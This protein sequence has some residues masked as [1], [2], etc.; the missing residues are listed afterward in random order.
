MKLTG[1]KA[2]K[3]TILTAQ[4]DMESKGKTETG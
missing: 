2:R 3:L 1:S 4:V